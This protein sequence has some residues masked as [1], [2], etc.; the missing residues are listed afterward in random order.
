MFLIKLEIVMRLVKYCQVLISVA[1]TNSSC[2][3]CKKM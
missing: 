2:F 3:K 1:C